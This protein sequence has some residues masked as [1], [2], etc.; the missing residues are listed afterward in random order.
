MSVEGVKLA[1]RECRSLAEMDGIEL[2][3]TV[4]YF[5]MTVAQHLQDVSQLLNLLVPEEMKILRSLRIQSGRHRVFPDLSNFLNYSLMVAPG[6]RAALFQ[7][8]DVWRLRPFDD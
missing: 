2:M 3:P 6:F 5:G 1:S 8:V 7:M 4:E